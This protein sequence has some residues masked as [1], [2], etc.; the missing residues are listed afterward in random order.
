MDADTQATESVA[1]TVESGK[2]T[3][4]AGVGEGCSVCGAGPEPILLACAHTLCR[5]HLPTMPSPTAP[6]TCP[7]CATRTTELRTDELALFLLK[8]R[9]AKPLSHQCGNCEEADAT[10]FCATCQ[11]YLCS[12]CL[13][14]THK[15]K[16]FASHKV[17]DVN[18]ASG[19]QSLCN[20]HQ[21]EY[22]LYCTMHSQLLCV[23]CFLNDKH[24]EHH[25]SCLPLN[26]AQA[27]VMKELKESTEQ[28]QSKEGKASQCLTLLET[29]L[30]ESKASHF[31]LTEEVNQV[32]QR[33]I[34]A[35]TQCQASL[36]SALDAQLKQKVQSFTEHFG[37]LQQWLP[38]LQAV[39]SL[40]G[41]VH[42]I[43]DQNDLLR[44]YA[45][46]RLRIARV[47]EP[48]CSLLPT[49]NTKF[50]CSV[51]QSLMAAISNSEQLESIHEADHHLLG[52]DD[53]LFTD[54]QTKDLELFC[55]R[56]KESLD[57]LTMKCQE[58][59]CDLTK[60]KCHPHQTKPANL[61]LEVSEVVKVIR[62]R[63]Q[64]FIRV[65]NEEDRLRY[66]T[67][68]LDAK[69]RREFDERFA[70][71]CALQSD[72]ESLQQFTENLE[73]FAG[74][75]VSIAIRLGQRP[76]SAVQDTAVKTILTAISNLQPNH[77]RRVSELQKVD[78]SLS[79]HQ[80]VQFTLGNLMDPQQLAT[81]LRERRNTLKSGG[82]LSKLGIS[83]LAT[84]SELDI[85][86]RH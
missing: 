74:E 1:E 82:G 68:S 13:A 83:R 43:N 69:H 7:V 59:V 28:L 39:S 17:Q 21:R 67:G 29:L 80:Q 19:V 62:D 44:V 60:R 45:S 6:F 16:I 61:V 76:Q 54:S 85:D 49:L 2:Q 50:E 55:N 72:F 14:V 20:V 42:A 35:V 47:I 64:E 31:T 58:L 81:A 71:L 63:K 48:P 5:T 75:M 27:A 34:D 36:L 22:E 38:D 23:S 78:N 51:V 52:D 18:S 46:M 56:I 65:Q 86:V 57:D 33:I 15:A 9:N 84:D 25:T 53:E 10:V 8:T 11:T 77:A 41:M 37:T 24:N 3:E 79:R 30:A 66:Q 32:S 26:D 70:R 12:A 4:V 40:A 73:S